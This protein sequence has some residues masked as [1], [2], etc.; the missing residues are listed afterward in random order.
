MKKETIET[1]F[2]SME[3]FSS[4][5]PPELWEA[6]E[7]QLTPPKKKKRVVAWWFLAASLLVGLGV[8]TYLGYHY[9]TTEGAA[10]G[11]VVPEKQNVVQV[12]KATISGKAKVYQPK[13]I[14][15]AS[16]KFQSNNTNAAIA[17]REKEQPSK[18]SHKRNATRVVWTAAKYNLVPKSTHLIEQKDNHSV[19]QNALATLPGKS[20]KPNYDGIHDQ[21]KQSETNSSNNQSNQNGTLVLNAT[22]KPT[23]VLSDKTTP[24]AEKTPTTPTQNKDET[25]AKVTQELAVLDQ[26]LDQSKP[27]EKR[28]DVATKTAISKWSLGVFA[29]LNSSQNYKNNTALG[30]TI[31]AKQGANF[32]VTASRT[33]SK[34]WGLSSGFKLNEL[35]QQL[36]NVSYYSTKA[37]L[38][39]DVTNFIVNTDKANLVVLANNPNYLF[40]ANAN[41]AVSNTI[42][43]STGEVSQRL[44]YFEMPMS[45]SYALFDHNKTSIKMNTGGFVGKLV[46]NHVFLNGAAIGGNSNVND[47]VYGALWSSTVQYHLFNQTQLYVEPGINYYMNPLQGTPFNQFQ[48]VFNF[49]MN[50]SF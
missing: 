12:Q 47:F 21:T 29:G 40:I 20:Q 25:N 26:I 38:G 48:W 18:T 13:V 50:W 17:E 43:V 44:K 23:V 16:K 28:E 15:I 34:K 22:A 3:D 45:V 33:I 2:S 36:N 9:I 6:I 24:K 7:E 46:S 11:L 31:D 37:T 14:V 35:G 10:R 8:P 39:I 41:A 19:S 4:V 5:P 49:G 1:L 42:G 27:T 32:G 30:T